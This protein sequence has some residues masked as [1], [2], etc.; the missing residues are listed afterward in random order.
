MFSQPFI[1]HALIVGASVGALSG[2][3]GYFLVLRAQVF[4]A[5]A[6]SHVAYTGAL[7]AL[8]AGVD[9]RLGFFAATI[10]V[11]VILSFLGGRRIADDVLTGTL[12]AWILGL[13]VLFLAIY[14]T[15]NSTSNGAAN[16]KV[17]FGSIFSI[18]KTAAATA[19]WIAAG[20]V[21]LLIVMA[22][23]LLFASIDA[24]VAMARGVPVRFL[25][26]LFLAIVGA[27]VAEAAQLVGALVLLGL[28]AAPAAAAQRLTNR[29][30]R[31][32][33][34]SATLAVLAVWGG[35]VLAYAV[36]KL[37]ATFT[38]M[39]CAAAELALAFL[40]TISRSQRKLQTVA[41]S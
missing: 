10:T 5:D 1:Q 38:I 35:V 14:T 2:M 7:A 27:T 24:T 6:L 23:P 22:R 18:S 16:A 32:L 11:G 34:L 3:V 29:P 36:P 37:P 17:L 30:W 40:V 28:L 13:G 31:A 26:A 12:F 21:M 20:L 4:A 39:L 8:A 19:S 33:G 15:Q 9:M 25:G 41:T